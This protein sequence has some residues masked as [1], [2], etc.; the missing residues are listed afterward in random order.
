[1]VP[2]VSALRALRLA[3][4]VLLVLLALPALGAAQEPAP[5][6]APTPAPAP[7]T[8]PVPAADPG[9]APAAEPAPALAAAAPVGLTLSAAGAYELE[10]TLDWAVAAALVPGAD[11]T[12][13]ALGETRTVVVRVDAHRAPAASAA[14]TGVRGEICVDVPAGWTGTD[15]GL[16]LRVQAASVTGSWVDLPGAA[17]T[18]LPTLAPGQR[19]CHPYEIAFPP[20]LTGAYRVVGGIVVA[21]QPAGEAIAA[22]ALP[23]P[24]ASRVDE[25][26]HLAVAVTC[27][28][29]LACTPAGTPPAAL[30]EPGSFEVAIQVRNEGAACDTPQSVALAAT[31]T[32]TDSGTAHQADAAAT[33]LTGECAADCALPVGHWQTHAGATPPTPDR[34]SPFLPVLLGSAGGDQ[35][36]EVASAGQALALLAYGDD[37][38]NGVNRLYAQLLA[39]KLNAA[40]AAPPAAVAETIAAAD[41]SLAE[42]G[43]GDWLLHPDHDDVIAWTDVLEAYNQ[44]SFDPGG[45]TGTPALL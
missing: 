17:S 16:G 15:A 12:P 29:G 30:T 1:M 3:A 25:E 41:A 45:C 11:A 7:A 31:L 4:V 19:A 43:P 40:R 38:A 27:P 6:P 20:A 44:G 21:G 33:L 32:E 8:D 39:A 10:E 18:I 28:P 24:A 23:T 36:V 34:I 42:H 2:P 37:R 22:F 14:F 5:A 13:I 9:V 35:T 26:A